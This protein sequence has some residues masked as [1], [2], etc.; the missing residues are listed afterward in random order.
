MKLLG[1]A[2]TVQFKLDK[3]SISLGAQSYC[4]AV[5]ADLTIFNTGRV[6]FDFNI[7]M[8]KVPLPAVVSASPSSG[9]VTAG[10]KVKIALKVLAGVPTPLLFP[11]Q[12][13][14]AHFDPV[15]FNISIDGLIPQ[16][17]L[18]LPRTN[19]GAHADYL[20]IAQKNLP[21]MDDPQFAVK[22][23]TRTPNVMG[24]D[25]ASVASSAL[26]VVMH[27]YLRALEAEADRIAIRTTIEAA[28]RYLQQ[29]F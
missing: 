2:S 10:E 26:R 6:K 8:A 25:S 1:E 29:T 3:Q 16:V 11:V 27:P 19:Q 7:S 20:A 24:K 17:V 23:A 12:I 28:V 18:S 14:I 13:S 9:M 5:E 15:D 21:P 22:D 4:R